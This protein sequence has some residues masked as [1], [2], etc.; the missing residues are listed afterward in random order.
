MRGFLRSIFEQAEPAAGKNSTLC[1]TDPK[2]EA[3]ALNLAELDNLPALSTGLYAA[4]KN[5]SFEI[6]LAVTTHQSLQQFKNRET[7][8]SFKLNLGCGS[9]VK[10]GWLNVDMFP[11][12][13]LIL[14]LREKLPFADNSCSMIYSEHFLEHLDYPGAA[15]VFLRE[16]LRVL[17][18]GGLFSVGVP[19]TEWPLKEYQQV[20]V[21]GYYDCCKMWRHQW[22]TT[23]LDHINQHFREHGGHKFAY[24]YETLAKRLA[25]AGFSGIRKREFDPDLDTEKRRLGTLYAEAVKAD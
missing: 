24:D 18:P 1:F 11:P 8:G 5:L 21:G 13:E 23:H 3:I 20:V 12:A 9:N 22:C 7:A 25:D 2:G 16:A 14:D 19:D 15:E 4:I 17:R 10:E 6:E